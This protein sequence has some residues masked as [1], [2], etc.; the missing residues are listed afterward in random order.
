MHV[1]ILILELHIPDAQ[2][3]KSKRQ[4]L[5][6]IKDKVR[7]K[8][9][10]SVAEFGDLDKW[11]RVNLGFSS[12]STDQDHLRDMMQKIMSMVEG[13]GEALITSQELEFV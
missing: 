7:A 3:L 6:S 5:K 12:I 13:S 10:V 9:N 2:S 8:Y 1:A 11:Q 4:V